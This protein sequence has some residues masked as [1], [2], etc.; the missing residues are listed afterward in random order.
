MSIAPVVFNSP[1]VRIGGS[2]H[3]V[4]KVTLDFLGLLGFALE[5]EFL[6]VDGLLL[7]LLLER[8]RILDVMAIF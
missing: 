4:F 5:E 3:G 2:R 7:G 8:L 1:K 6:V